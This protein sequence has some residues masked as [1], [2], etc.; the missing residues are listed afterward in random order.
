MLMYVRENLVMRS[1]MVSDAPAV[2]NVVDRNREYLR[3]WLPW[4]DG[5]D[6]PD[7]TENV[8]ASWEK[9][10]DDKSDVVLGIFNN[11][12]YV[13][14]IGLH[15]IKNHK[16]SSMIGYW[17]SENRQGSGIIT[18]CVR[19]LMDFAFSALGLNRIYINCA[20][21]NIKS[22][23]IPERLGF[24][25]EGILQD[26]EYLYGIFHDLI[27]YG[28]V[29]R[30]WQRGDVL[31]LTYPTTEHEEA[32]LDYRREWLDMNPG[33]RI[34]G[35]W[36]LH[37]QHYDDYGLWLSDISNLRTTPAPGINFTASTYFAFINDKIIGT[38]QVR[39]TLNESLM[40]TGGHIGYGVRPTERRKGY[41]SKMLMLALEQTRALGI[42]KALL[43]CDKGN[44]GSAKTIL[45]GGGILENEYTDEEGNITQRYWITTT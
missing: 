17:L 28:I 8:I 14:N 6:S 39:H 44:E 10:L 4:V 9:A 16:R 25:Q 20:A 31:Y 1:L 23:A 15:D 29:E 26:C 32:A 2:Y 42:E 30:N 11:G 45:S 33:K 13:G 27:V 19:A 38:V 36:G 3:T 43:T 18:D 22:R 12:E 37:N 35:S 24:V 34:H 40:Q 7:V 21:D 5:T 41:G